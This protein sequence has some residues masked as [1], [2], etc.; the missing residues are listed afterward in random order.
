MCCTGNPF[1]ALTGPIVIPVMLAIAAIT[2][3]SFFLNAV[4]A[5]AITQPG[6]R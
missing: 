3:A 4:F 6:R 1:H 2:A 5:F